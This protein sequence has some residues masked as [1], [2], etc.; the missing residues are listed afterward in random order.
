MS[1]IVFTL[2]L[3]I[4]LLVAIDTLGLVVALRKSPNSVNSADLLRVCITWASFSVLSSFMCCSC[5]ILG[6][7]FGYLAIGA[8][9]WIG[10][11][12]LGGAEKVYQMIGSGQLN[13][14][15][16]AVLDIVKSKVSKEKTN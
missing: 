11:P 13:H 16:K 14:Y 15:A 3:L 6:T 2:D 4:N 12:K 7:L 9:L 8:K 5:G 1:F 10:L